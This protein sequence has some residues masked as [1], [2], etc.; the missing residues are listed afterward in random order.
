[1]PSDRYN[2]D[3]DVCEPAIK[4]TATASLTV[5]GL[6][7]IKDK[8]RGEVTGY[9][10]SEAHANVV[11]MHST[12]FEVSFVQGPFELPFGPPPDPELIPEGRFRRVLEDES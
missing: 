12:H 3:V 9:C 10:V 11:A 4:R 6:W 2:R 8:R 1:M 5:Q 7:A